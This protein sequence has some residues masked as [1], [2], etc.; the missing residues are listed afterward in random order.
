M[1][2][3]LLSG[4]FVAYRDILPKQNMTFVRISRSA[5]MDAI[6]RASL[7]TRDIKNRTIRIKITENLMNIT[8]AS[9]EGNIK[10]DIIMEKTGADLEIG[11][12]FRYLLDALKAIDDEE[13]MMEF[14]SAVK[15]CLIKPV[16]GESYEYLVLPV[17]IPLN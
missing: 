15:P 17:R 10:E 6:E 11:F 14:D 3:R 7:L 2:T 13:I 9:E 16:E 4:E 5:L 1:T 12:N 8:S